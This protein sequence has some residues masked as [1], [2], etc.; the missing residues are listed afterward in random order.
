MFCFKNPKT[1]YKYRI[2]TSWQVPGL[3]VLFT[4]PTELELKRVGLYFIDH[5]TGYEIVVNGPSGASEPPLLPKSPPNPPGPRGDPIPIHG[6]GL[7]NLP[8]VMDEPMKIIN[9]ISITRK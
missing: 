6:I 4:S 1:V 2:G 8:A 9:S 3:L 5:T 7:D